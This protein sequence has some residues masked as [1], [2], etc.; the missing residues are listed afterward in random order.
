[1]HIQT[2]S[3]LQQL[4]DS[5]TFIGTETN[6]TMERTHASK[7]DGFEVKKEILKNEEKPKKTLEE[8]NIPSHNIP[9]ISSLA[10]NSLPPNIKAIPLG[11]SA[12]SLSEWQSSNSSSNFSDKESQ[13]LPVNA[14]PSVNIPPQVKPQSIINIP[15][16]LLD[17]IVNGEISIRTLLNNIDTTGS[18]K[19]TRSNT[20]NLVAIDT[21]MGTIPIIPAKGK[22]GLQLIPI[23]QDQNKGGE[24]QLKSIF[25]SQ[26]A[27]ISIPDAP[28]VSNPPFPLIH[29]TFP[30]VSPSPH[31]PASSSTISSI[32]LNKRLIP[33]KSLSPAG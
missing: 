4:V 12:N 8:N 19:V 30:M 21:K 33:S 20:D 24:I 3:P 9:V 14:S 28:I 7:K 17:Q 6:K 5:V 13:K 11:V 18:G 25:T 23:Q 32:Q 31:S 26:P 15:L 16:E 22:G 10:L 27:P 1:M 2:G 29:S